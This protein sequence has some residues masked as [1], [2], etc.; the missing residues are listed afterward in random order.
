MTYS[1]PAVLYAIFSRSAQSYLDLML[2]TKILSVQASLSMARR[3]TLHSFTKYLALTCIEQNSLNDL[4]I[5]RD[6]NQSRLALQF[7]K[8]HGID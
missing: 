3:E 2:S 8:V 7:H 6:V 5:R 4:D 1:A